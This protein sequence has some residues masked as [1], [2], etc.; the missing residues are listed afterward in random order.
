MPVAARAVMRKAV[1]ILSLLCIA[2]CF[3]GLGWHSDPLPPPSSLANGVR[4]KVFFAVPGSGAGAR[5]IAAGGA[6]T[7]GSVDAVGTTPPVSF[8]SSSDSSIVSFDL[9]A[10]DTGAVH[11]VSGKPGIADIIAFGNGGAEL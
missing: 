6:V 2:A 4:G 7:Q 8:V 10:S 1:G 9:I 11:I 5:P 3:D